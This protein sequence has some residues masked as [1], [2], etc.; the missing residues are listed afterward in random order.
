VTTRKK[1]SSVEAFPIGQRLE[2]LAQQLSMFWA[3]PAYA[4]FGILSDQRCVKA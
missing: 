1:R 4:A 3:S 2:L